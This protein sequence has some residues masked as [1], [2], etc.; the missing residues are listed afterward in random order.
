MLKLL[1]SSEQFDHPRG[2]RRRPEAEKSWEKRWEK[3]SGKNAIL[4]YINLFFKEWQEK[5]K[6]T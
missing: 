2:N 4:E 3:R 5:G 6:E 1:E